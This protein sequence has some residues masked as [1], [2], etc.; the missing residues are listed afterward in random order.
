MRNYMVSNLARELQR[1]GGSGPSVVVRYQNEFKDGKQVILPSSD[2][3]DICALQGSVSVEDTD[4]RIMI[5]DVGPCDKTN[6]STARISQPAT[7]TDRGIPGGITGRGGT[8]GN[9]SITSVKN[10]EEPATEQT[11]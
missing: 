4:V 3:I 2:S 10:V 11:V 7:P 1:E 9:T 8:F 5:K 6:T